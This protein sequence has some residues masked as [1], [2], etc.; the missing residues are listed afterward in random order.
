MAQQRR[1]LVVD[2]EQELTRT[3][4]D[5]LLAQDYRVYQAFTAQEALDWLGREPMD[6]VLL[7]LK[8]PDASGTEVL[9][10]IRARQ[11]TLPVIVVTA[12]EPE[13]REPLQALHPT[14]I[15]EK[16]LSVSTL[17]DAIT[18][19]AGA[20]APPRAAAAPL[21]GTV[22]VLVVDPV[23]ATGLALQQA[24]TAHDQPARAYVVEQATSRQQAAGGAARPDIV[25][26]NLEG[27]KDGQV[28]AM[29]YC[30]VMQA[31]PAARRPRDVIC[32]GTAT[33]EAAKQQLRRMGVTALDVEAAPTPRIEQLAATIHRL[34]AGR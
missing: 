12:Y 2:D 9:Q 13:H 27:W 24:L 14:R 17:L 20:A 3:L 18:A 31:G 22:R 26:V 1:I 28:V 33:S 8:L 10:R 11:P 4:G 29:E 16:P 23:E 5:F 15:L 6:L 34:A 19:A 7:D 32:Y 21:T 25:L 30:S